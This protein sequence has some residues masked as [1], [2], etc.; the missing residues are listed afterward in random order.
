MTLS[1]N[2]LEPLERQSPMTVSTQSDQSS[3]DSQ[4]AFFGHPV[5]THLRGYPQ[6][7][8]HGLAED[9]VAQ[10]MVSGWLGLYAQWWSDEV[11]YYKGAGL[12]P[13]TGTQFNKLH[14]FMALCQN[15]SRHS[16]SSELPRRD[17]AA[18][19]FLTA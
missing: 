9:A 4:E 3:A 2:F 7:A 14:R 16:L 6:R 19:Y 10:G 12:F 1:P 17:R 15:H 8:V 18:E 13:H 5:C 11:G